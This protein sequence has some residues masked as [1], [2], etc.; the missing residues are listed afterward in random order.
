VPASS[1]AQRVIRLLLLLVIAV[2]ALKALVWWLEPRMAFF[3][4]RG[5]QDTPADRQLA[6]AEVR[7]PTPDGET[8]HA[9]W[10]EHPA[11]RAQVV[12]WH[13][14]GGNLSLWLDV[15]AGLRQRGF[16]VLAVDYRGY[17]ASTGRP[18]ERGL[19]LDA[20]ASIRYFNERLRKG[21][22]P[23][24]W[25][26]RSI[27]APVAAYAA[28]V[29][30]PDALVLETP[31]RDVA[32][33]L[34]GNPVMRF[35]SLFSSYRFPTSEFLRRYTG[36]LLVIHGDRDTIIPFAAGRRVFDAAPSARKEFVTLPG[37]DHNDLHIVNPPAYWRAIDAFL[38]PL[39]REP[40]TE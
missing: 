35:L 17:G 18:S 21:T 25:W 37:A 32:T 13:G 6:F 11:P 34:A 10:L 3:P 38:L 8:L 24:L 2:A 26:G 9:W 39:K 15:I 28:S 14:N 23:V 33:L 7:I 16:S 1:I 40:A 27:G 4:S 36:P 29:S 19:Y 12:F 31:F 5:V 22:P 30:A 20:E